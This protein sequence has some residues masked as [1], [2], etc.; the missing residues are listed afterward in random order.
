MNVLQVVLR[1]LQTRMVAVR[2]ALAFPLT[3]EIGWTKGW[4][5]M[6]VHVD[7]LLLVLP[8]S[9]TVEKYGCGRCTVHLFSCLVQEEMVK[10]EVNYPSPNCRGKEWDNTKIDYTL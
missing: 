7:R 9:L 10:P 4:L 1:D 5:L 6:S 2:V 3:F 8:L